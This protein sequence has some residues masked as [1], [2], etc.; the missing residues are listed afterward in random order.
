M[1][2]VSLSCGMPRVACEEA[3]DRLWHS[4]RSMVVGSDCRQ[5]VKAMKIF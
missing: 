2:R 1:Y 4:G 3:E 5:G